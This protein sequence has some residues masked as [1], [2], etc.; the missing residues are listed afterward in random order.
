VEEDEYE[1]EYEEEEEEAV[2]TPPLPPDR[3]PQW[4]Q[5]HAAEVAHRLVV[6]AREAGWM[7]T[8]ASLQPITFAEQRVICV[9]RDPFPPV[10]RL[11]GRLVVLTECI[12]GAFVGR[13]VNMAGTIQHVAIEGIQMA[14][15]RP[16]DPST[17]HQLRRAL[18][19]VT[20]HVEDYLF[21]L[22]QEHMM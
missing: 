2:P 12:G 15:L 4:T 16:L 6:E 14:H 22:P 9:L 5:A 8:R 21:L 3:R 17:A 10:P 13:I 19:R 1:E 7:A 18:A 11:A 20:D